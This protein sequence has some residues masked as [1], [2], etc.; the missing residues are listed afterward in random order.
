MNTIQNKTVVFEDLGTREYQPAWDY[1]ESLMKNII[2]LKIKNRDLPA[3]QHIATPNHFLL[4]EHPHVY[5]LGRSGHEENMLAGIDKLKEIDAT[6][7][8]VNR[9]G[10]ITYHGYGQIV[11]YP[12]LDLENFFTDIHKYMRKPEEVII[13]TLRDYGIKATRSEG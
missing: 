1:Q 13:L 9:G 2:D 4:V 6:F 12:I 5:T 8:K 10:D 7:V 11:G 3:E